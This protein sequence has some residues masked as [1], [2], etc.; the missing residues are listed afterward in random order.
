MLDVDNKIFMNAYEGK[1]DLV[2]ELCNKDSKYISLKD[3]VRILLILITS[4]NLL[5]III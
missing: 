5:F 3:T 1:V 4:K 2:I